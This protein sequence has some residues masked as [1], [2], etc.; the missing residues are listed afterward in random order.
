LGYFP[1]IC[2]LEAKSSGNYRPTSTF[3]IDGHQLRKA[4][5]IF[6]QEKWNKDDALNS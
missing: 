6:R 3:Y 4:G 1:G 2:F 5:R